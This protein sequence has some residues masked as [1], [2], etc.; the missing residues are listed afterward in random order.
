M[1]S[2]LAD[3]DFDGRIVRGIERRLPNLDIVRI[4]DVGLRTFAD[5]RVLE[6]AASEGRI[7][8][9]HDVTT[10]RVH[11][12]AR[13]NAG[14]SMTGVFELSQNLRIGPAID[15][16]VM[17]AECSRDNEWNGVIRYLPL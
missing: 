6:F 5:S 1:I 14:E 15:A 12:T 17:I 10:M 9:T 11:A 8:L 3:E 4:Q 7:L 13:I 16:I 2:F